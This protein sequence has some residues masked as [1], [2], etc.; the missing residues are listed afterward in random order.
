MEALIFTW[1]E[2]WT[3]AAWELRLSCGRAGG[4]S[5]DGA[6][7]A[8]GS[9]GGHESENKGDEPCSTAFR[10]DFWLTCKRRNL[11]LRACP[12]RPKGSTCKNDYG[13]K[14]TMKIRGNDDENE[15]RC[16]KVAYECEDGTRGMEHCFKNSSLNLDC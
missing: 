1:E 13:Y 3:C 2:G 4:L 16:I 15:N 14:R 12:P 8:K 11:A 5:R 10:P 9:L 6:K 7:L